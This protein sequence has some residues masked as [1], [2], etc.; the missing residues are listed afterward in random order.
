MT[1]VDIQG[2]RFKPTL[3]DEP[4]TRNIHVFK[5]NPFFGKYEYSRF[6][7]DPSPRRSRLNQSHR[8][9]RYD[10]G[11]TRIQTPLVHPPSNRHC[12]PLRLWQNICCKS[13]RQKTQCTTSPLTPTFI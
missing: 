10:K 3:R 12:R 4:C 2:R 1:D 9:K 6:Q 13:P 11:E 7:V 5:F 8:Q